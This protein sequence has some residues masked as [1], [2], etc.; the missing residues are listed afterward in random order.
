MDR[1]CSCG[2]RCPCDLYALL[3]HLGI[4]DF[5]DE[6]LLKEMGRTKSRLHVFGHVHEGYGIG[7]FVY[8][9]FEACYEDICRGI[10]SLSMLVEIIFCSSIQLSRG[11]R[12]VE[13]PDP[14]NTV[15]IV[16]LRNTESRRPLVIQL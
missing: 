7:Y 13:G 16:G 11:S 5:G 6:N 8:D 1:P 9:R 15:A 14:I 10:G 4:A 3:F 2:Y 12:A